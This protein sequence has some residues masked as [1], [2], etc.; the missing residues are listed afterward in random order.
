MKMNIEM[1]EKL[2]PFQSRKRMTRLGEAAAKRL[3]DLRAPII[4]DYALF[5]EVRDLYKGRQVKYLRR[6]IPNL[7]NHRNLRKL[8]IDENIIIKDSDYSHIYRILDKQ[9]LPADEIVCLVDSFCYISHLSAMQRYGITDRRP[10]ALHLTV[11][12]PR[13]IKKFI[14]DKMAIDYGSEFEELDLENIL[15]LT[16]VKH[17]PQVRKRKISPFATMHYGEWIKVRGSFA[18]ISS[19]GQTFID[20]LDKPDRCGGMLHVLE[21][22]EKYAPRHLEEVISRADLASKPIHKV[23]AGYILE[24]RMGVVD[25][26]IMKW[27]SFAQRGSSRVLDPKSPFSA[28]YSKDWDISI[29]VG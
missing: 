21:T 29:N 14:C 16:A 7:Q 5:L 22:W 10:R 28:H 11:P 9:E 23:R 2:P 6:K 13:I 15:P 26:R 18:K 3:S 4:S 25:R 27:K 19:I 24:E 12:S 17:P 20:M 1:I 8:L